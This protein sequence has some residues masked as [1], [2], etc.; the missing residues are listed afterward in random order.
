[1]PTWQ[2]EFLKKKTLSKDFF[3]LNKIIVPNRFHKTAEFQDILPR[4]TL[5]K[6]ANRWKIAKKWLSL[7]I[8]CC[9]G[10]SLQYT[11]I[12]EKE[13]PG[14]WLIFAVNARSLNPKV[15]HIV[16]F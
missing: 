1:M 12:N 14:V 6:E 16:H 8:V 13:I 15:K 10:N 3:F 7:K 9:H 4:L 2:Y 11:H 5:E